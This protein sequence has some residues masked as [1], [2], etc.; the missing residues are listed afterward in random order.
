MSHR[1]NDVNTNNLEGNRL[2]CLKTRASTNKIKQKAHNNPDS[3]FQEKNSKTSSNLPGKNRFRDALKREWEKIRQLEAKGLPS[4][5]SPQD[6]R[7]VTRATCGRS[8]HVPPSI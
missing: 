1:I 7:S 8:S 4:T 2:P 6:P 5:E 3:S